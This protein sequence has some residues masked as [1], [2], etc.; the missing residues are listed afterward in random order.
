ME[1]ILNFFWG[2]QSLYISEKW[3]WNNSYIENKKYFLYFSSNTID[4]NWKE[5]HYLRLSNC[6]VTF[7][8]RLEWEC[9]RL[10]FG[11][12]FT[13]WPLIWPISKTRNSKPRYGPIIIL[14]LFF[15]LTILLLPFCYSKLTLYIVI[16]AYHLHSWN[17]KYKDWGS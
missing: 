4:A 6:H 11:E 17:Y 8:V 10:G 14:W 13:M 2:T 9:W 15:L 16:C 12:P 1:I 7:F 5:S 3:P